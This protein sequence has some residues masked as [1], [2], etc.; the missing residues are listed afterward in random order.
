MTKYS[1]L[2][3]KIE[4]KSALLSNL[5]NKHS[6]KEDIMKYEWRKNDKKYYLPKNKPEIVQ[7]PPMKFFMLDGRGNPNEAAFSEAVGV[8]Y[9]I[10]YAVKM[11]PKSGEIPN[12]YFEYTVFPLEGIWDLDLSGGIGEALDKDKLIYTIM[13]RQPEFVDS[14]LAKKVLEQVK[15]KKYHP[16]LEKVRFGEIEEGDCVQMM[17]IGSYDGEPASFRLMEKFCEENGLARTEMRHR[18]IY[19][20]DVRKT[21]PAKLKTVLRMRVR[22]K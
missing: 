3:A 15:K 4:G 10:A 13:I 14:E 19:I 9:S 2:I 1:V 20:S 17:H 12:G 6:N 7:V 18:E 5:S 11:M 22:N 21:E 16:L 8:L